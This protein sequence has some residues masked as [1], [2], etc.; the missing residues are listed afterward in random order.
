M[1]ILYRNE[2]VQEQCTDVKAAQKIF[3]GDKQL[4][5][6]LLARINQIEAAD[7]FKRYCIDTATEISLF[8]RKFGWLFC[9]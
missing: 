5:V 8:K 3:G 9:Y 6:K 2:K 4:A 1:N 7:I